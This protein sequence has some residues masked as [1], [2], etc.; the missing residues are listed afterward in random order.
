MPKRKSSKKADGSGMVDKLSGERGSQSDT[1]DADRKPP[2]KRNAA[3][4]LGEQERHF[5]T[6][7]DLAE[8]TGKSR[9]AIHQA[10]HR[11]S[12]DPDDLATVIIYAVRH[13]KAE[14]RIKVITAFYPLP[15]GPGTAKKKKE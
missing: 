4:S 6:Y 13:A 9:M 8:F 15:T 3:R 5:W 1:G 10:A 2:A 11:G 7:D 14:M 12:F